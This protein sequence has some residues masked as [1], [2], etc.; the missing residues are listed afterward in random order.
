MSTRGNHQILLSYGSTIRSISDNVLFGDSSDFPDF[1]RKSKLI[2]PEGYF[3]IQGTSNT[4]QRFDVLDSSG[5]SQETYSVASWGFIPNWNYHLGY[6]TWDWSDSGIYINYGGGWGFL[7]TVGDGTY[8]GFSGIPDSL[9]GVNGCQFATATD[10]VASGDYTSGN[11]L[12]EF[13]LNLTTYAMTPTLVAS[14]TS[15]SLFNFAFRK[16]IERC[17]MYTGSRDNIKYWDRNL[18]SM[19]DVITGVSPVFSGR[20][21]C[22]SDGTLWCG[23]NATYPTG[24]SITQRDASDGSVLATVTLPSGYSGVLAE[25]IWEGPDEK[26]WVYATGNKVFGI[27]PTSASIVVESPDIG[28]K[29]PLGITESGMMAF[30]QSIGSAPAQYYY[31][32]MIT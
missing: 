19:V 4:A 16:N 32:L 2:T 18:S 25:S 31:S 22:A 7:R 9:F 1:S 24:A 29:V 17:Y 5:S 21:V 15:Y 14:G 3:W 26:I 28:T 8:Q 27:D 12:Y 13:S 30:L 10:G 20:G 6:T 11:R 23:Q